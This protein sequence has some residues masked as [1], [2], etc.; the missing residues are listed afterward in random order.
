MDHLD[1]YLSHMAVERGMSANTIEAYSRDLCRFFSWLGHD[2]PGRVG[3]EDLRAHLVWLRQQGL[4]ARSAARAMSAIRGHFRFLVEEE[5]ILADPT[6][7]IDRP[8]LSRSLPDVITVAEMEKL[9]SAP[10]DETP[11]GVR[12]RAMLEMLYAAGLRVSE[13]TGLSINDLNLD[14]MV[15]RVIGKGNKERLSPVNDA[16]CRS[17]RKYLREARP[18]LA[19]GGRDKAMFISRRGRGITRQAVWHRIKRYA[20]VSGLSKK[21]SPHTFRHSFATHLLEGGADLRAVQAML[22]HADISTTQIYTH[23][24]R[25][26]LKKEYDRYHPR[27]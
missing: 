14:A 17:V 27:S 21:V 25:R 13:L 6:E 20:L 4:S 23:V 22:G 5:I 24:D 10:G 3:A 12:D 19:K 1:E 26:L 9:L 2:D 11:E 8:R 18:V 7:L 16:A 15:V